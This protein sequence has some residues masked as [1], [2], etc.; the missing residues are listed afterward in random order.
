MGQKE[1]GS[2]KQAYVEDKGSYSKNRLFSHAPTAKR[3]EPVEDG[4]K[5]PSQAEMIENDLVLLT[6]KTNKRNNLIHHPNSENSKGY[7]DHWPGHK[8][9]HFFAPYL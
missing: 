6:G 2:N 3:D 7:P 8:F 1:N 5:G 9:I 4:I